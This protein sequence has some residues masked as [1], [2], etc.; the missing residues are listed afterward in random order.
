MGGPRPLERAATRADPGSGAPH[1]RVVR[2]AW[3]E[4]PEPEPEPEAGAEVGPEPEPEPEAAGRPTELASAPPSLPAGRP[5]AH[6]RRE[7]A[8]RPPAPSPPPRLPF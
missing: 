2:L 1:L 3:I 7:G 8:P 4:V 5:P 6:L